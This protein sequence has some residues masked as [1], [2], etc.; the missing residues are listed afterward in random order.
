MTNDVH[1]HGQGIG[2]RK[3]YRWFGPPHVLTRVMV[4]DRLLSVSKACG[5]RRPVFIVTVICKR[6]QSLMPDKKS[7]FSF[8]P[9]AFQ[10]RRHKFSR[11]KH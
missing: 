6:L 2:V 1:L 3:I 4:V 9:I 11:H 5:D 8:R 10:A 7:S